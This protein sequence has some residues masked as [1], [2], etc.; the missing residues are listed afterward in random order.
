MTPD[1]PMLQIL[2]EKAKEDLAR[3]LSIPETQIH[4]VEATEVE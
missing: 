3:R 4:L 2:I 1:N